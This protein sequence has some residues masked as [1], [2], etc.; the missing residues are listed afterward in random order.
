MDRGTQK[1]LSEELFE[2]YCKRRHIGCSRIQ[3]EDTKRPDYE[4]RIGDTTII[5]EVKEIHR[6]SEEIESD[7]LRAERGHGNALGQTPGARV[8]AKINDAGPQIRALTKEIYPGLLVLFDDGFVG[9]NLDPYHVRVAM[10]GLEQI[11]IAL[12]PIS[13]GRSPYSTGMSYGPKQKMT[14]ETNTSISA[15]AALVTFGPNQVDLIVYHN[16]FARIPLP[17]GIVGSYEYELEEEVAGRTARW[18]ELLLG[19]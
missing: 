7:R 9:G 2:E 10:Y 8:R 15:V 14:A 17:K 5:T 6:N 4:L 16:K 18:R 19:T 11:H 13:S 1:T 3:E 12:P